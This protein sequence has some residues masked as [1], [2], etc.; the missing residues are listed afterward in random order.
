MRIQICQIKFLE[1]IK[2][3]RKEKFTLMVEVDLS[4]CV[5]VKPNLVNLVSKF[6]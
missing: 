6:Y 3:I 2:E 5:L 1:L 4:K